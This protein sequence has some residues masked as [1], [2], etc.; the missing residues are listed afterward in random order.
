VTANFLGVR[1]S[2]ALIR[3]HGRV[4]AGLPVAVSHHAYVEGFD[5]KQATRAWES[6]LATAVKG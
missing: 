1:T 2:D 3:F 5:E 6:W 4:P